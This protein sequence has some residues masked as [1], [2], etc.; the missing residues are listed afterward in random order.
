[1]GRQN[2]APMFGKLLAVELAGAA[3]MLMVEVGPFVG[4]CHILLQIGAHLAS[5][6]ATIDFFPKHSPWATIDFFPK[7]FLLLLL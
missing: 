5:L 4:I 6:W 3:S 1:M 2:Q 7:H